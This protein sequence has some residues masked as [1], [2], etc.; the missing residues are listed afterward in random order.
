MF[1]FLPLVSFIFLFLTFRNKASG[2]RGSL[3]AAATVWGVWLTV[4]T[5]GL[6]FFRLITFGWILGAWIFAG[7]VSFLIF[8]LLPK[9]KNQ[10]A[11]SINDFT[12]L[13]RLSVTLL[14]GAAFIVA[15]VGLIALVAAPD[16]GDAMAYHLGRVV[17]WIQ[18]QSV[19]HYPTSLLRQIYLNPWAE[20]AL[21]HFQILS[22]GDRLANLIQW[23]SMIG[24]LA[25]VSLIAK[26]FGANA[27]GQI[28]AAVVC[29]TIPMGICQASSAQN[30]YAVSFWLVC[31]A[32]YLM[33]LKKQPNGIYSLAVGASLGLAVLTK[34]TAYIYAFPFLI[35][36]VLS[37]FRAF[38]WKLW[39]PFAVIALTAFFINFSHYARNFDL[40]GSPI[41]IS[42]EGEYK[43]VNDIFTPSSLFSNITR[44]IGLHLGTPFESVNNAAERVILFPHTLLGIDINDSR[45]T[46]VREN[47]Y[48]P[49]LSSGED[50]AGNPLSFYSYFIFRFSVF[51]I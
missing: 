22:G 7:V 47:F 4:I 32:Y 27:R 45:T 37:G 3:L 17:H 15:V 50:D 39:K 21:M 20:F 35:L 48:I 10:A 49:K 18:N 33:L 38:R 9:E 11:N 51:R 44:N 14:V 28:F 29:V 30:D 43:L 5:E 6:S 16:N 31:F 19:A 41:G 25:G 24:S 40:F 34:A 46:W 12:S 8:F 13:S 1:W 42:Q 2:W 23:F 36:F 26:Q